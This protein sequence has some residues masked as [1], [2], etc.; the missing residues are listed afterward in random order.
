MSGQTPPPGGVVAPQSTR[1][2][3]IRLMVQTRNRDPQTQNFQIVE[4]YSVAQKVNPE[5]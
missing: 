5:R 2:V 3:L 1:A 4:F